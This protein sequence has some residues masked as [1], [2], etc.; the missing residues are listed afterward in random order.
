MADYARIALAHLRNKR[1][2]RSDHCDRMVKD[3]GGVVEPEIS[4]AGEKGRWDQSGETEEI[5]TGPTD[6]QRARFPSAV[7]QQGFPIGR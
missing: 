4:L 1:L 5:L 6:D 2:G 7:N 3:R